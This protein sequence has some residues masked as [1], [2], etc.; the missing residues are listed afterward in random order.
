MASVLLNLDWLHIYY[1]TAITLIVKQNIS[2]MPKENEG[3]GK[4]QELIWIINNNIDYW[5]IIINQ[6]DHHEKHPLHCMIS[7]KK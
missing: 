7:N 5:L 3:W 1:I 4:S 2:K 6:Q